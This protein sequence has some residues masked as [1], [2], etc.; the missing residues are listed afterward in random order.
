MKHLFVLFVIGAFISAIACAPTKSQHALEQGLLRSLWKSVK[1]SESA[2]E[3]GLL[4]SLWKKLNDEKQSENVQE[5]E[6]DAE[7]V[8]EQEDNIMAAIESFPE[9]AQIQFFNHLTRALGS[10]FG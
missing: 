5:Q 1:Q 3:Q 2:K 10:L 7:D 4:R 9:E 8:N 6:D